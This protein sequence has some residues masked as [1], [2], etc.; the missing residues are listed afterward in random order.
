MPSCFSRSDLTI[1]QLAKPLPCLRDPPYVLCRCKLYELTITS[2][3]FIAQSQSV[4]RGRLAVPRRRVTWV[5]RDRLLA[6]VNRLIE[7]IQGK[8]HAALVAQRL[9]VLR[10]NRQR[11]VVAFE[12]LLQ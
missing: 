4:F 2:R 9:Q 7:L 8:Q 6:A 5:N 11:F 3:G 12:R 1:L 10:P